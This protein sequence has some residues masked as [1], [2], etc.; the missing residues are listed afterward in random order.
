MA[1]PRFQVNASN[2]AKP[3]VKEIHSGQNSFYGLEETAIMEHPVKEAIAAE[4]A[5]TLSLKGSGRVK[6]RL[7]ETVTVNG[8]ELKKGAVLYGKASQDANRVSL[9]ISAIRSGKHILPVELEAFDLDGM[10]GIPISGSL[11]QEIK[12]GAGD[13]L[14]T[15]MPSLNGGISMEEQM[16]SAGISAA[17]G[18]F[19]KKSKSI[20]V[21]LKAG[22]PIL[23]VNQSII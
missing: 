10:P 11:Q 4:I 22:H 19:R 9:S 3:A 2:E 15:G 23:L 8:M 1:K 13:A 12:E 7:L 17:K 16:A 14:I 18:L 21:T 6:I 20:K 5:E